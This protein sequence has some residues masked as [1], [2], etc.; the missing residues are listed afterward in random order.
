MNGSR[1][2]T[3]VIVAD[4]NHLCRFG[5]E[6][7][8]KSSREFELVAAAGTLE[9]AIDAIASTAP[10]I[11][12]IAPSVSAQP[13]CSIVERCVAGG[14]PR[15]VVLSDDASAAAISSSLVAGAVGFAARTSTP[16]EMLR[17]L[18]SAARGDREAPRISDHHVRH[19]GTKVLSPT[20]ILVASLISRGHTNVEIADRLGVSVRTVET[21]R[22]RVMTKLQRGTRAALVQWAL[23]EGILTP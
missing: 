10:H 8:L 13:M 15:I 21:H 9:E 6:Q 3:R 2:R 16:E 1:P 17:T 20:E 11:V 12:V 23:D 19:R 4:A 7:L 5:L 22:S 18:R 14:A